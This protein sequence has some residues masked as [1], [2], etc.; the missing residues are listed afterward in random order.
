MEENTAV[1]EVVLV[2]PSEVSNCNCTNSLL[3]DHDKISEDKVKIKDV[4]TIKEKA[5]NCSTRS[6]DDMMAWVKIEDI[7]LRIGDKRIIEEGHMLN[8]NILTLH[9]G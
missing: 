4:I 8:I 5:V 6:D 9:K 7:S 3:T 2:Q 1:N